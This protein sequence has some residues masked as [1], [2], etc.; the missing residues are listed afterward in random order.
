MER[1]KQV[2]LTKVNEDN[3]TAVLK[4]QVTSDQKRF[5]PSAAE[6]MA[7]AWAYRDKNSTLYA[8]LV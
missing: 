8:I 1:N 5:V 2:E 3:M 7:R 6:I 4:L